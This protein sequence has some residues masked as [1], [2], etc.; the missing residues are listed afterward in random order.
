MGLAL[1]AGISGLAVAVAAPAGS[2]PVAPVIQCVTGNGHLTAGID[3]LGRLAEMRWPDPGSPDQVAYRVPRGAHREESQGAGWAFLVDGQWAS[4]EAS[5][6]EIR[7]GYAAVDSLIITTHFEEKGGSRSALQRVM[8]SPGKDVLAVHLRLNGFGSDTRLFWYQNLAPANRI[9]AGMPDFNSEH[10]EF[11]DFAACYDGVAHLLT[12]FRPDAP[13]RDDWA[14]A[15]ALAN[16]SPKEEAWAEFGPGSYFCTASPNAIVSAGVAEESVPL[17]EPGAMGALGVG[18]SAVGRVHVIAELAPDAVAGGL[19]V[20]VFIGAGTAYPEA[21]SLAA[22]ARDGG[23]ASLLAEAARLGPDWL[24]GIRPDAEA[25]VDTRCVLDLLLC[26]DQGSGAVLR[27][28]VSFPSLAYVSVFD[29]VWATAALDWLGYTDTAGR[30]LDF[31]LRA[32]RADG[33]GG[34]PAGSLPAALF[35]TGAPASMAGAADPESAAWLIAACWRHAL[36]LPAG[37]RGAYLESA[38]PALARC[39]DYLAREPEV[40]GVLAGAGPAGAAPLATLETHYLGLECIGRMQVLLER[41]E[42]GQWADRR[43]ELYHWILF[44]RLNGAERPAAGEPW[45]AWWLE[46]LDD[47]GAAGGAGLEALRDAALPSYLD[48]ATQE[49]AVPPGCGPMAP[50]ALRAAFRCLKLARRPG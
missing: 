18:L 28:P 12:H 50:Y 40:G 35:T 34:L 17:W 23:F 41:T 10:G 3:G 4:F 8:V 20:A 32:V 15:R 42:P 49:P 39:A 44:R 31:L 7:H 1:L 45:I 27:S 47:T 29:T 25:P 6:W 33:E 5:G 16:G 38:W 24:R 22:G 30:A 37:P 43:N 13:G 21:R 2:P 19:E 9:V 26:V 46:G 14:K 11:N 36:A 48:P